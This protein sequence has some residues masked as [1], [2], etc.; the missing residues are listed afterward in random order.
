MKALT[1]I[2]LVCLFVGGDGGRRLA[3]GEAVLREVPEME[4]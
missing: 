1:A 3:N 4:A 2:L